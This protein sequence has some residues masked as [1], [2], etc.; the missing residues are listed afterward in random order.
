M[1]SQTLQL[2]LM[3]AL[4]LAL[5]GAVS[6][7][8]GSRRAF[9]ASRMELTNASNQLAEASTKL[10]ELEGAR[11]TLDLQVQLHRDDLNQASNRIAAAQDEVKR[12]AAEAGRLRQE[13]ALREAALAKARAAE[14]GWREDR[15]GLD[16]V[17]QQ[18][19]E[20]IRAA[21]QDAAR[22][23]QRAEELS[24]QRN[25]AE[26]ARAVLE[27]QLNDPATL[28]SR[29]A[30]AQRPGGKRRTEERNSKV[31]INADGTVTLA[32]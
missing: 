31:V 16:H 24:A 20:E 26:T 17:I 29:L 2:V 13:L 27:Q 6:S 5:A 4:A 1:K 28:R 25:Q 23:R 10:V 12:A 21:Q 22:E 8:R 19:D 30:Q 11:K 15:A 32:P 18:K 9:E 3:G 7:C 14:A